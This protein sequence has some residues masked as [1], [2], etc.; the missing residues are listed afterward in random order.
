VSPAVCP[1]TNPHRASIKNRNTVQPIVSGSV[2]EHIEIDLID[3]SY[4]PQEFMG[5]EMKWICHIKDHFSK[6]SQAVS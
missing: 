1:F 3:M 6:F 5:L 4:S 2:F